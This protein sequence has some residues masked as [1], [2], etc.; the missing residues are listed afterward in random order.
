LLRWNRPLVSLRSVEHDV[1]LLF[2]A[3]FKLP[4]KAAWTLFASWDHFAIAAMRRETPMAHGMQAYLFNPAV[5]VAVHLVKEVVGMAVV[6]NQR[7][8]TDT[9]WRSG[10]AIADG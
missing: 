9:S 8:Q 1:Q 6:G 4:S 7:D 5:L 3:A 2:K 10:P